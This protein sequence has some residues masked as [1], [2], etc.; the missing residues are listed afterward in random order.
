LLYSVF[1]VNSSPLFTPT[2][3]EVEAWAG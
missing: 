3:N 2:L 1:Q